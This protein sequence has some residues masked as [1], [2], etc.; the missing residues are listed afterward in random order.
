MKLG[1]CS[2]IHLDHLHKKDLDIFIQN[3]NSQNLDGLIISGDIS[4]GN[5]IVWHLTLLMKE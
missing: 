5:Y 1:F 2:D 3:I 4:N